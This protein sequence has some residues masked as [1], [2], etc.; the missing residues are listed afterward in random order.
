MISINYSLLIVILNFVVLLIL[1]NKMLYKPISNFLSERKNKISSDIDEAKKAK[2]KAAK[3]VI[4]KKTELKK[5]AED[6]RKMLDTAK[7]EAEIK[8]LDII[9]TARDNEKKIMKETE[10]QLEH[11]K[12]KVVEDIESE[13]TSLIANLSAKFLTGKLDVKRDS[14]LIEKILNERGKHWK[15]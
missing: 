6:I 9:K 13:L 12:S 2:E 5:S 14:E 11:E 7:K 15:I 8:S 3:L 4:E 10:D 1:L